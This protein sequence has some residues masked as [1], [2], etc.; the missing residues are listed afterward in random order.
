MFE[1][2]RWLLAFLIKN[3]R[4]NSVGYLTKIYYGD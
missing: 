2:V 3:V 1:K 4:Q